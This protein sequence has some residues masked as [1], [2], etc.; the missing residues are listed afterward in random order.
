MLHNKTIY[1]LLYLS[2]ILLA[3]CT[4]VTQTIE[5]SSAGID[6]I[7]CIGKVETPPKG[8]SAVNDKELLQKALGASGEGKLCTGKVFTTLQAVTVYR[9]WSRDKSYSA[10]GSWW[11]F[12]QPKGP[13]Q[14]YRK[15]NVICPSWSTLDRMSSCSIKT[16]TKVVVGPGQSA[17]CENM[18]YAKSGVNQVFIQN[19]TRN[20]IVHVENC[21]AGVSWP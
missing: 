5:Q 20:N 6:G 7:P 12:N 19:D 2:L 16:G 14:Q 4:G 1:S 18:I 10:F 17:K 11:S 13:R 9:V 8:L 21:T 3:G 15:D